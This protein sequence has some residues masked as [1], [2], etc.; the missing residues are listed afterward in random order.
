MPERGSFS[1]RRRWSVA[2]FRGFEAVE[3]ECLSL[4]PKRETGSGERREPGGLFCRGRRGAFT[5]PSLPSPSLLFTPFVFLP[6]SVPPTH[7]YFSKPRATRKATLS[8]LRTLPSSL[9]SACEHFLNSFTRR[10]F[11]GPLRVVCGLR[12]RVSSRAS[13]RAFTISFSVSSCT[14]ARS[15]GGG[16]GT[17]LAPASAGASLASPP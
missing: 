17:T 5:A 13:I 2:R 12:Q 15:P 4:S 11:P 14:L 1:T 6:P 9:L 8:P 10:N 7:E 3:R 16:S